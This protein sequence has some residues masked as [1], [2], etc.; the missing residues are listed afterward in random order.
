MNDVLAQL[1]AANPVRAED[2]MPLGLPDRFA[3]R[4]LPRRRLG[5]AV[6]IAAAAVAVVAGAFAL[7]NDHSVRGQ[8]RRGS[9]IGD[10]PRRLMHGPTGAAGVGATGMIGPSGSS[11]P[12]GS[13]GPLRTHGGTGATGPSGA[14]DPAG[15][16]GPGLSFGFD[17]TGPDATLK[18]VGVT[19]W[20][21]EKTGFQLEVRYLGPPGNYKSPYPVV[22]RTTVLPGDMSSTTGSVG[23]GPSGR[24]G[25]G[26]TAWSWS[27]RLNPGDWRGGCQRGDYEID[28]DWDAGGTFSTDAS[29]DSFHCTKN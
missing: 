19:V 6:A 16:Q 18:A 25:V 2:L 21:F 12:T 22:Y 7:S 29:S 24:T 1:A 26:P 8:A 3:H 28:M 17:R 5:A 15:Q 4:P 20:E 10:I 14:T 23:V 27:G 13:E 11:G 9:G